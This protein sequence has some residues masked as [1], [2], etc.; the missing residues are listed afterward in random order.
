[1]LDFVESWQQRT[2]QRPTELVFDSRLTTYAH[3]AELQAMGFGFI[4]L[5]RRSAWLVDA[6]LAEPAAHWRR[7]P[8]HH[9]ARRF[10]P[11]RILEQTI[12]LKNVPDPLRQIALRDHGHDRPTLLIT[13]QFDPPARELVDRYARRMGIENPMA[14]AVDFFHL[15]ALS[16]VVPMKIDVDVDVQL[17]V[18][19]SALYLLPGPAHR[20][21]I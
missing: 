4:T 8:L 21:A 13:N 7:I 3:L 9:I 16:A 1:M 17:T 6:L 19:A 5:R 11:P 14:D 2:G 15:N 12:E 20:A 10:R 18:M